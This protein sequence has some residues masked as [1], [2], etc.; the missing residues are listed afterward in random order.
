MLYKLIN[1]VSDNI[2]NRVKCSTINSSHSLQ[3]IAIIHINPSRYHIKTNKNLQMEIFYSYKKS[4]RFF[5]KNMQRQC[6]KFSDTTLWITLP[7]YLK[8]V[9]IDK[10]LGGGVGWEGGWWVVHRLLG[11]RF[12]NNARVRVR[13]MLNRECNA[14]NRYK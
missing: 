10:T 1:V 7:Y 3:N 13:C 5:T 14:N 6:G 9:F 4:T 2:S 12:I 8:S 11:I